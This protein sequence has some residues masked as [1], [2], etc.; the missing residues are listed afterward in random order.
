M[1]V[2][3]RVT[4]TAMVELLHLEEGPM[5]LAVE[6]FDREGVW[7]PMTR[8]HQEDAGQAMGVPT[9]HKYASS[10][11]ASRSDPTLARLA[12]LLDQHAVAPRLELQRLLEQL[13]VN[14]ALGNTDAHAKNY[15]VL[16]PDAASVSLSPMYDVVPAAVVNPG[17]LEMGRRIHPGEA[18]GCPRRGGAA[19]RRPRGPARRQLL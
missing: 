17:Q 16:H 6:R 10:G 3:A 18:P 15:G 14:I 19:R 4:P 13:A 12:T 5:T 2:A 9:E 11:S 1:A 7:P 8:Q